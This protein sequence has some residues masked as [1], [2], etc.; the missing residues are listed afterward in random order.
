MEMIEES[1]HKS[2]H[3]RRHRTEPE[4]LRSP[5]TSTVTYAT[6]DTRNELLVAH[7]VDSFMQLCSTLACKFISKWFIKSPTLS[8]DRVL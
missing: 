2:K 7:D 5:M 1:A 6:N 3:D 4:E 8:V